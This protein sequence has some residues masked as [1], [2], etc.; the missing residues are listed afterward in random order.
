MKTY[1][2]FIDGEYVDPIGG[3][4]IDSHDPYRGEVW[5]RIPRG[6]T[7]DVDRAVTAAKRAMTEGPWAT[8]SAS[9]RGKIMRRLGDLVAE[10]A[11][12]LAELTAE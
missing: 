5:A 2:L 6:G 11:E 3:A 1:Q 10:N 7:Q 12:R 8:M 4:W 9:A